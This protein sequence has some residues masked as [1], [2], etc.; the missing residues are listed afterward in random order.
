ML[1]VDPKKRP[2]I[3]MLKKTKFF[4]SFLDE[5]DENPIPITHFSSKLGSGCQLASYGSGFYK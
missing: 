5:I 4:S 2:T 3:N 1:S